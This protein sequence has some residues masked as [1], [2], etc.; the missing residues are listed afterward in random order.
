[1][2]ANACMCM[3]MHGGTRTHL[4]H[5]PRQ[6]VPYKC[7]QNSPAKHQCHIGGGNVRESMSPHFCCPCQIDVIVHT[8]WTGEYILYTGVHELESVRVWTVNSLDEDG[9]QVDC[10]T[11]YRKM[12][13]AHTHT[14]TG[15]T[16]HSGTMQWVLSST[17]LL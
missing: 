12:S 11:V 4:K 6:P 7:H 15:T 9:T 3:L 8:R 16:A 10:G 1:M 5:R 2:A 13:V 14:A 17:M